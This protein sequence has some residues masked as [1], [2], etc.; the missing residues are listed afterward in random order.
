MAHIWLLVSW[1]T[2]IN[3]YTF[4]LLTG[5]FGY[6][7][8]TYMYKF[9][10]YSYT[11]IHFLV[12]DGINLCDDATLTVTH[13][14]TGHKVSTQVQSVQFDDNLVYALTNIIQRIER[15]LY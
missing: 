1:S 10:D 2:P 14:P 8:I 6:D 7:I 4:Y 5:I 11:L 3:N 15:E 13:I 9:D 12:S